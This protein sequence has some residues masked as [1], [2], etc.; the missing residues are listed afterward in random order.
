MGRMGQGRPNHYGK[1][2][3]Y[4]QRNGK[5]LG[6]DRFSLSDFLI[7]LLIWRKEGFSTSQKRE[8]NGNNTQGGKCASSGFPSA[9]SASRFQKYSV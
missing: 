2:F 6:I 1:G 3:N 9:S 4:L 8:R 7:E 5:D